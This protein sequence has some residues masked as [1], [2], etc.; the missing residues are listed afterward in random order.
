MT[1]YWSK[2]FCS[3]LFWNSLCSHYTVDLLDFLSW[4]SAENMVPT[5]WECGPD[6]VMSGCERRDLE[7]LLDLTGCLDAK[8]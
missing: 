3:C 5:L 1:D 4:L 8:L 6:A 2:D 7:L